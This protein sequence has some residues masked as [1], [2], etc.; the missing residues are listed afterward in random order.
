[1]KIKNR[2]HRAFSLVIL[3]V[4]SVTGLT[5]LLLT[6]ENSTREL[7]K[8]LSQTSFLI[9]KTVKNVFDLNEKILLGN[10]KILEAD[11]K[12]VSLDE[13]RMIASDAEHHITRLTDYVRVPAMRINGK[14]LFE[15]TELVDT[16]AGITGGNVS[17]LQLFPQGLLQI[18]TNIRRP[19][20][21]RA[22][23]VY[24][25]ADDKITRAIRDGNIYI[26][27][28]F[29][30]GEWHIVAYKPL[31][32]DGKP[33]G[34]IHAGIKPDIADLRKHILDIRIGR[35]GHP[36]IVDTEGI[37]V[38]AAQGENENV[39]HL[40]Y[41]K[42][43]INDRKDGTVTYRDGGSPLGGIDEVVIH[44]RYLSEMEWIVAVGSFKREFFEN[45]EIITRIIIISMM[46]AFLVAVVV[47]LQIADNISRP[48]NFLTE[49]MNAVKELKYDFSDFSAVDRIKKRLTESV[50]EEEEITV[51]TGTF[52]K[53]LEEL[54]QAHRQLI[55]KHRRYR[56]MEVTKKINAMLRPD[57]EILRG[58]EASSSHPAEEAGG[59]YFDR[60]TG[61]EGQSWYA[62]GDAK[63]RGL[64]AG[65][66]MS[67]VQS[68]IN[69]ITHAMSDASALE[70]VD[71]VNGGLVAGLRARAKT[72]DF[73]SLSMLVTRPDGIYHYAGPHES[74]LIYRRSENRCTVVRTQPV[75][76]GAGRSPDLKLRSLRFV[77]GKGDI[78]FVDGGATSPERAA[79]ILEG[80]KDD[81]VDDLAAKI[82]V[83]D[84]EDRARQRV[85]GSGT[86]FVIRK[87]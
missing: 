41:I 35:T 4:L 1:M 78:V 31:F 28:A 75:E 74:I 68:S 66:I 65:L 2:L 36:Y 51:M 37:L 30:M 14:I 86:S 80:S 72:D 9:Y 61:P 53:M 49:S 64:A 17:I 55:S 76:T 50:T 84:G 34:A 46:I 48:I 11:I 43:M 22:T 70:I 52:H 59:H 40:P 12:T 79:R 73:L 58:D 44:Y 63:E 81:R 18:A 42:K 16:V 33:I 39:Y 54:E 26:G 27:K 69:S 71:M 25:P 6:R 29:E 83:V 67:M 85:R 87:N 62:I 38:I 8:E 56:E 21:S 5:I 3:S 57:L 13:N 15:D 45:Q 82:G 60:S 23:Q 77:M 10:L 47:S 19:D 20:G 32:V 24:Y 7:D